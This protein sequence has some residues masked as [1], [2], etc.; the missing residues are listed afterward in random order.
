MSKNSPTNRGKKVI[1]K[2]GGKVVKPV[3]FVSQE[4][5]YITAQYDGGEMI[6]DDN[7]NPISWKKMLQIADSA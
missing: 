5:S 7:G 1:V 4:N 3:K 2:Y 6:I